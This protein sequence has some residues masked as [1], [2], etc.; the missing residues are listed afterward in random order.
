MHTVIY[1]D[2]NI[3]LKD[4]AGNNYRLRI[5]N[6]YDPMHPRKGW[7]NVGT[8]VCW[9]KRYNLGDDHDYEYPKD[10]LQEKLFEHLNTEKSRYGKRIYDFIKSGKAED[11]RLKYD[12]SEREWVLSEKSFV[13]GNWYDIASYPA[14]LKGKDVPDEFLEECLTALTTQELIDFLYDMDDIAI[15]PLYLYDHSGITMSTGPF[16]CPWDSGQVGWIYVDKKKALEEYRLKDKRNWEAEAEKHLEGEVKVYDQFI[17][18]SV[19]GFILEKETQVEGEDEVEYV[20]IDSC[21]GFY[22]DTLEE[23]GMFDHIGSEYKVA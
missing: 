10:F 20:E 4:D 5:K 7:D 19:Y 22:G 21:W 1:G 14:R 6:D 12:P 2:L 18:G 17:S 8:M 9:H 13:T 23:S 16:S 11:A 15:I 3:D